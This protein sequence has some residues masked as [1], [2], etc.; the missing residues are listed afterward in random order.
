MENKAKNLQ[1]NP[2]EIVFEMLKELK[3]RPRDIIIKRF[4]L[5]GN[6]G[7]T[8]EEIGKDLKITRERVRQIQSEAL[9]KLFKK[10]K[11]GNLDSISKF[12][13]SVLEKNGCLMEENLFLGALFKQKEISKQE[14]EKTSQRQALLF[15]LFLSDSFTKIKK[16]KTVKSLWAA[17]NA[18]AQLCETMLGNLERYLEENEKTADDKEILKLLNKKS[19]IVE[20]NCEL[21]DEILLNWLK[22][23]QRIIKSP[24]NRWGVRNNAQII[25][26]GMKDKAY[27]VV[28]KNKNP[29]HFTEITKLI[30]QLWMEGREA[31]PQTVHN[32]LIKDKRFVL[33]GRGIYA[34]EEWGF[35][36]GTV[37]E[38]LQD[39]LSEKDIIPLSRDEIIDKVLKRRLVKRNTVLL[40]LQNSDY[41]VKLNNGKYSLKI[42][43]QTTTNR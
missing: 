37:L 31:R 7:Q 12:I 39:V 4:N 9:K 6:G 19:I 16:N 21:S 8:L 26:R 42:N 15:I 38:V 1:F 28:Q 29:L 18:R 10:A 27:L 32:E 14:T 35:Q 2:A 23:S 17:D 5:H 25:P 22:A 40:N 30:N 13:S 3:K 41:F 36:T 20:K 34:L 11:S 24:L 43:Q 33:V